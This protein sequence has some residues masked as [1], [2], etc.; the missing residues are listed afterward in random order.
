MKLKISAMLTISTI[1]CLA[2]FFPAMA[3][4]D[5]GRTIKILRDN[6]AV[7]RARI[8]TAR[9]AVDQAL[10]GVGSAEKWQAKNWTEVQ[11][12]MGKYQTVCAR[13]FS[14]I[15]FNLSQLLELDPSAYV[16]A[17][18]EKTPDFQMLISS[19]EQT[20]QDLRNKY[21]RAN[22]VEARIQAGT[23]Q[24]KDE[25]RKR[26]NSA[27]KDMFRD[28]VGLPGPPTK[29]DPNKPVKDIVENLATKALNKLIG[30]AGL[31]A[32]GVK[33]NFGLY[34]YAREMQAQVKSI[35][36][37]QAG[38]AWINTFRTK[39]ATAINLSDQGLAMLRG[40]RKDADAIRDSSEE[41]LARS[42]GYADKGR[43]RQKARQDRL[44][45]KT[46]A[47]YTYPVK[48]PGL[49]PAPAPA[50][51]PASSYLGEAKSILQEISAAVDSAMNG[52]D[53][54]RVMAVIN[55]KAKNLWRQKKKAYEKLKKAKERYRKAYG[56]FRIS[57]DRA[58]TEY[59]AAIAALRKRKI[60]TRAAAEAVRVAEVAAY[61]RLRTQYEA[62]V[63]SLRP[64]AEAVQP[65]ELELRRLGGI[66][67]VVTQGMLPLARKLRQ[68]AQSSMATFNRLYD[69]RR[70]QQ[71]AGLNAIYSRRSA[72]HVH[73][74]RYRNHER[75]MGNPEAW[76]KDELSWG[77]PLYSLKSILLDKAFEIR[78]AGRAVPLLLGQYHSELA[79]AK[80]RGATFREELTAL[81]EKD[82]ML[83]M[84][85]YGNSLYQIH[86]PTAS[87][88]DPESS[89]PS[90]RRT[91]DDRAERLDWW[92]Q[93]ITDSFKV[94]E[95]EELDKAKS[96][97]YN[98]LASRLEA[99]AASIDGW[100]ETI[101]RYKARRELAFYYLNRVGDGKLSSRANGSPRQVLA[102]EMNQGPWQGFNQ[103]LEAAVD[104]ADKTV[105]LPGRAMS[106]PDM[107]P[108]ERL[109]AV[110]ALFY[111]RAQDVLKNYIRA[112]RAG[113]FTHANKNDF[114]ALESAWKKIQPL[115]GQ[116]DRLTAAEWTK[117]SAFSDEKLWTLVK[118]AVDT[119]NAM[120][121]FLRSQVNREQRRLM[122][123]F[124]WFRSYLRFKHENLRP[125]L[126]DRFNNAYTFLNEWITGYPVAMQ[127]F[128][129]RQKHQ[130]QEFERQR[131]ARLKAEQ[132]AE[133]KRRQ[134]EEE[135]TLAL[136]AEQK[137][138][139]NLYQQFAKAYENRDS[140]GV[141]QCIS[142]SW[143]APNDMTMD[144]LEESLDN[145]FSVFDEV[146][147]AISGLTIQKT[148]AT[149]TVSYTANLVGRILD[150]D[151]QHRETSQVTDIVVIDKDGPKISRTTGGRVWLR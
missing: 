109:I 108:R 93:Q 97:D 44:L 12:A 139:R 113:S 132:E 57:A 20:N 60:T 77:K 62:A 111:R 69:A 105:R 103:A 110:Q 150:Q 76:V 43:E 6:I 61:T 121:D 140:G 89:F 135:K 134:A 120:P 92:R 102:R 75:S 31:L 145:S 47:S 101:D 16:S 80:K 72:I 15:D 84:S 112:K 17:G 78:Y 7:S 64:A 119:Y 51:I 24:V 106:W 39:T 18:S 38:L 45:E 5:Q 10:R 146:T 82:A 37:Y 128:A 124:G 9:A 42:K 52:G 2:A 138:I 115:Y 35:K 23:K 91:R 126:S 86:F 96:L 59:S 36:D 88:S 148:G 50:P 28:A 122:S 130:Q 81:L 85:T 90:W 131:L 142:G 98:G 11:G 22:M 48:T 87:H 25:M 49:W 67:S 129:E 116:L 13:E 70:E 151:L 149:Y 66:E 95:D 40:W 133:K 79:E 144:D 46:V 104:P 30:G 136:A 33:L 117:L 100:Q 137:A 26:T 94:S 107:L 19:L 147:F 141:M 55:E 74:S 29:D 54:D 63:A 32:W 71:S 143:S 1:F 65:L 114:N 73:A 27:M 123:A 127:A 58:S 4:A 14:T 34:Y 41:I 21:D 56:Q 3:A 118:P 68:Y 125:V 53:P 99:A 8:D 83:M